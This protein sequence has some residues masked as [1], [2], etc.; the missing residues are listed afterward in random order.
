VTEAYPTPRRYPRIPSK[1]H[2]FVKKVQDETAGSLS[3]T[4]ELG[5]GGC[6]FVSDETWEPGTALSMLISVQERVIEATARVVY[7]RPDG[8][9]FDI[10]VE[11]LELDSAERVILEKLFEPA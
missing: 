4:M 1:N 2:V 10:G 3:R 6:M 11:F 7:G 5:L 9:K 8:Q